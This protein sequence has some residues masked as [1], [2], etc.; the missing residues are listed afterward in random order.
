MAF[1]SRDRPEIEASNLFEVIMVAAFEG[2]LESAEVAAAELFDNYER[3]VYPDQAR[4]ALA[5]IYM[6]KGPRSGC[7]RCSSRSHRAG[8]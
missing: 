1:Q 8:R 4:L 7:G 6:D 3:T 2:D 5:R